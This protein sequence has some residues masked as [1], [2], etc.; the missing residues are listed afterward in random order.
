MKNLD[1]NKKG[2]REGIVSIIANILLFIVK[3][4][5]GIVSGSVAIMADAWHTLSDSLTSIILIAG[6]KLSGKKS[7]SKHPFGYGRWE[8]LASIFIGFVL[9][10]VAYEFIREA[11]EK[12]K[13]H[14]SAHYGTIAIIVTI[15]SV[16]VKEGLAQYALSIFRKTNLSTVKADAW[17]HRSD[18]LSS[19]VILGGI[20]LKNFFW[21]IDS[22]MALIVS[23]L[24]FW[25]V[26]DIIK[27]SIANLLGETPPIELINKIDALARKTSKMNLQ[28][29]HFHMHTYGPHKELTFH[30]KVPEEYTIRKAHQIASEIEIVILKEL[31]IQTTIHTEPDVVENYS[32]IE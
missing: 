17:H 7:D 32:H 16:L 29:H 18:A 27:S 15:L 31:D 12:F 19:L 28:T 26:Y 30:I 13:L 14:E 5:A 22:L 8:Q 2:I 20:F 1:N 25:A 11:I 23:L 4:W 9:S 21:W 10:V 24:L 3:Y 6:I